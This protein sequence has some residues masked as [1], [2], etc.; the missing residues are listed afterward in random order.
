M[1]TILQN[2]KTEIIVF[3]I[4][5]FIACIAIITGYSVKDSALQQRDTSLT[6]LKQ[7]SSRYYTALEREQLLYLYED[8][9]NK[10]KDSN[11]VGDENR[12]HWVD[13]VESAS[14][15]HRIPYLK[16]TI[17]KQIK[18]TSKKLSSSYPG[19]DIF[20]SSMILRMQLLHEGDLFNLLNA[21]NASTDSL[22]DIQSCTISRNSST[23]ELIIDSSSSLNFSS[24]CKLN[25][26]TIKKKSL[27]TGRKS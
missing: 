16:Y 19:I 1:L 20:Q 17:E 4:A 11:I 2:M 22:F 3:I 15:K 23:T 7:A 5:L 24:I 8:K 21:I 9:F 14:S 12:L 25:W 10:L 18:M 27:S 6:E 26:Y 13:L